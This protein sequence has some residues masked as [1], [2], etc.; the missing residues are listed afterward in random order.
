MKNT[1][2][3]LDVKVSQRLRAAKYSPN[4]YY[5]SQRVSSDKE[6]RGILFFI[7]FL[8]NIFIAFQIWLHGFA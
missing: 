5:A 4:Y 2:S 8:V 7:S 6:T 3:H 1:I